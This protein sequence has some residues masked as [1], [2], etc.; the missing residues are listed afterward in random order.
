MG[1]AHGAIPILLWL[2]KAA[3]E[4]TSSQPI[5]TRCLVTLLKEF[6]DVLKPLPNELPPKKEM[7][8]TNPLEKGSELHFRPI[9]VLSPRELEEAK[10]Q[11]QEY[12]ENT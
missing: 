5:N 7:A 10:R 1:D 11:V 12:L 9:I 2:F 3:D 4:E 8:H 6:K